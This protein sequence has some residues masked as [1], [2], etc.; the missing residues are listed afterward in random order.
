MVRYDLLMKRINLSLA[1]D[2]HEQIRA[3]AKTL[4]LSDSAATRALVQLALK[5]IER[6]QF[7]AGC[8]A[9]PDR[10]RARL[11][12]IEEGMAKLRGW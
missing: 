8:A 4:A 11:D 1:D 12:E 2:E 9:I 7:L 5:Q 3:Y 10:A 6:D